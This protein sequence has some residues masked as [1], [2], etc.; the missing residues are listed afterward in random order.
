[1][2][3]IPYEHYNMDKVLM[4]NSKFHRHDMGHFDKT[5]LNNKS[6]LI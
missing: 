1:M 3:F 4:D 5:E 2:E 6:L